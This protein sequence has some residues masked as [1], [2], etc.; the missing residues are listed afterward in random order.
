MRRINT[1][2]V[3]VTKRSNSLALVHVPGPFSRKMKNEKKNIHC[4]LYVNFRKAHIK[5]TLKKGPPQKQSSYFVYRL[6]FEHTK[7]LEKTMRDLQNLLMSSF[8][9][10]PPPLCHPMSAYGNPLPP[11]K[12]WHTLWMVPGDPFDFFESIRLV[13]YSIQLWPWLGLCSS[14]NTKSKQRSIS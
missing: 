14:K 11:K 1:S 4:C 2:I 7:W 5:S 8:L 10:P 9:T 12:C 3:R 13:E 6:N